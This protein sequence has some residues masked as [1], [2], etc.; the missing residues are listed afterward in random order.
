[1]EFGLVRLAGASRECVPITQSEYDAIGHAK[2]NLLECLSIEEKFD[3]VIENYLELEMT[4]LESALRYLAMD[5]GDPHRSDK[6]RG[7]FNRRLANL[8]TAT[9]TYAEQAKKHIASV[10]PE[11]VAGVTA[12]FS[13]QY[14]GRLGYR[15]MEAL[16]NYVQHYDFPVWLVQYP[17]HMVE[18][19]SGHAVA[20][21][22]NP[23]LRPAD[24][25]RDPDFKKTVL[26]ELEALGEKVDLKP[27]VRDYVEGLWV[28]HSHIR[29]LLFPHT[30]EW[31]LI[32]EAAKAKYRF[33]RPNE[34]T[35]VGVAAVAVADDGGLDRPIQIVTQFNDYRRYLETKNNNLNGLAWRFVTG[36][37]ANERP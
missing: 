35:T 13:R 14:D 24:L 1:M 2:A 37:A 17:A 29:S 19:S 4:L 8:L 20:F 25:R 30:P 16:R 5:S 33:S 23:C 18:R 9:K 3:F 32:L 28:V 6:E 26:K 10:L 31:E 12:G 22:V 15:V 21:A 36:E 27:L 34:E 7:L 11:S